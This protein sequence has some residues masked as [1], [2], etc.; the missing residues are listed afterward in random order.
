MWIKSK[1]I[2]ILTRVTL[3]FVLL[4]DAQM[5]TKWSEGK[6]IWNKTALTVAKFLYELIYR[7]GCFEFQKNDQGREFHGM[8]T[9]LLDLTGL[10]QCIIAEYHNKM[11]L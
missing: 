5:M 9:C 11:V 7:H 1:K 8:C 2:G 10:E 3:L 4:N 6:P